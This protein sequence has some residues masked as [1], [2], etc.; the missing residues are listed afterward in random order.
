MTMQLFGLHCGNVTM[1]K[2]AAID[3]GAGRITLPITAYLITHPRGHVLFDTGL[4]ADLLD[5]ACGRLGDLSRYVTLAFRPEDH[6][7]ARLAT[8]EL[9]P[10]DI[11][12]VVN[13]HLHYDHAGGNGAFAQARFFVQRRE[14]EAANDPALTARNGYNPDDYRVADASRV[15]CVDGELDLYGD[16]SITLLP[17]Y[18]HTPGHQCLLVR[19]GWR[20]MLLSGDCC[21]L[22][23]NVERCKASRLSFDFGAAQSSLERLVQLQRQGVELIIGHDPEQW[24]DLPHAPAAIAGADNLPGARHG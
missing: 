17:T 10:S 13:S 6:I 21:Y 19:I 23:E 9:T 22:R 16:G 11:A 15:V 18:G 24:R 7:V 12:V 4:H 5:P 8:L 1:S 20:V 2:R 14:W 3:D